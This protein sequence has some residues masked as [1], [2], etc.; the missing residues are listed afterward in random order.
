MNDH[1]RHKITK[2][3]LPLIR[4]MCYHRDD[5]QIKEAGL[6]DLVFT[7]F[8]HMADY[9]ILCGTGGR[10]VKA[11]AYLVKRAGRSMGIAAEFRLKESYIGDTEPVRPFQRN[12]NFSVPELMEV[13]SEIMMLTL[14]AD[15]AVSELEG[16][17]MKIYIDA[18]HEASTVMALADVF[19]PY[20]YRNGQIVEIRQPKPKNSETSETSETA[21]NRAARKG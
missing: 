5:L 7:V 11:L 2:A 1:P 20:G 8:P 4:G 13:L 19:Y 15:Q 17:K 10:Q 12:P 21:E 9:P 6:T 3:F 18:A 16:E 14:G